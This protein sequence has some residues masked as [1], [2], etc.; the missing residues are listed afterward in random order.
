MQI[1]ETRFAIEDGADPRI[2]LDQMVMRTDAVLGGTLLAGDG[3]GRLIA[4]PEVS[5]IITNLPPSHQHQQARE[6][7]AALMRGE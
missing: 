2:V 1:I 5:Q 3:F 6:V 7:A 4:S